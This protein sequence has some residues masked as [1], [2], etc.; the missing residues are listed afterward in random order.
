M[1]MIGTNVPKD[2]LVWYRNPDPNAETDTNNINRPL[3]L[4]NVVKLDKEK[5]WLKLTPEAA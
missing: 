2:A 4:C 5:V 1:L 3:Y